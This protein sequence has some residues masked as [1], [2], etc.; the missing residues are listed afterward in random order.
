MQL[1]PGQTLSHYRLIEKIGEG[2]MGVV[3]KAEDTVLQRPVALKLLPEGFDQDAARLS[4]FEREARFLASLNHP[5]I[6]AIHGLEQADGAR[7]LDM[8]L[9][10]GES[11]AGRLAKGRLG[12]KESL[13][14]SLEIAR[15]LEAAHEKGVIHR[16]L[17]PGNVQVTPKGQVKVLDFG[18][19][20]AFSAVSS[21]SRMAAQPT[22]T[23][24]TGQNVVMGTTS[25][26]S[27]EQASGQ[28]LDKRTDI[29]AFGCVLYELLTG[30]CAFLGDSVSSTLAAIHGQ[31]PDWE[32]LPSGTPVA[33]RKLLRRCL[34][35][36]TDRRLRDIGD[37]RIEIEDAL[38]HPEK[39]R[40][41]RGPRSRWPVALGLSL[42]LVAG[43]LITFAVLRLIPG[44][45]ST[46]P[47]VRATVQGPRG[48]EVGS[49]VKVSPD[50]T[51]LAFLGNDPR[52]GEF[53]KLYVRRFDS[54][55]TRP[56]PGSDDLIGHFTFSPDSRWIAFEARGSGTSRT[57]RLYRWPI[58]GSAPPAELADWPTRGRSLAWLRDDHLVWLQ[59]DIS[60]GETKIHRIR[61]QGGPPAAPVQVS[62]EQ[63]G[64]VWS[65]SVLAPLPDAR[66]ALTMIGLGRGIGIV[67]LETGEVRPVL[68]E[69]AFNPSWSTTGHVLF[70][71]RGQVLAAPF[72]P[73]T[74]RVTGPSVPVMDGLQVTG[75]GH[76]FAVSDSH[77]LAWSDTPRR[78]GAP[79]GALAVAGEDGVHEKWTDE[80]YRFFSG[81]WGGIGV[82][83]TA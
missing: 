4:R 45:P 2:G 6:A 51:T 67:D 17:K 8:E 57:R 53:T 69:R 64:G 35:K 42:A 71:R 77:V 62:T 46:S 29:W 66:R 28:D 56:V 78:G 37:A 31:D 83:G 81:S 9:V 5:N 68:D 40:E 52:A 43:A 13:K 1:S 82:A 70:S 24:A 7:F 60:S 3:W 76:Q 41:P 26:M 23:A 20:K 73:R 34:E 12:I 14:L 19:A 80:P 58:D 75:L 74:E 32:R 55:D 79:F 30:K 49:R 10:P 38:E 18:L 47:V 39:P 21:A 33:I 27:P 25:Y 16:D 50:G 63:A 36:N 11:L 48:L 59:G 22:V 72:D 61:A 15:A 65:I 54:S 44:P